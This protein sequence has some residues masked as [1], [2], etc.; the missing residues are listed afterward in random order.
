YWTALE[1]IRLSVAGQL[2]N[3]LGYSQA[4]HPRLIQAATWGGVYA[5]SFLILAI[6]C[7]ITLL[8]V[9]HTQRAIITGSLV[10]LFVAVVIVV[11]PMRKY[12]V[13]ESDRSMSVVAVQPNVPMTGA[14][15]DEELN[16]LLERHLSLSKQ[17][18]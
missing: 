4:Y 5:V 3:A 1:L 12:A 9:N 18:L 8:I 10:P 2:W 16:E 14:K 6:N 7:A 13:Y 17:G 15:S 11:S